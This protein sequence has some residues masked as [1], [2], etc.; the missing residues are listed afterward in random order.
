MASVL[1][2]SMK[3]DIASSWSVQ[4][5]KWRYST[6]LIVAGQMSKESAKE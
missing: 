6:V 4:I 3:D 1:P 2:V 5:S